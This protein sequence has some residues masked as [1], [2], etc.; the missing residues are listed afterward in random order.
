MTDLENAQKMQKQN[1]KDSLTRLDEIS[2]KLDNLVTLVDGA[3]K[4]EEFQNKTL[5]ILN[6]IADTNT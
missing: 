5:K 4:T 3:S 1:A 6:Q 2:S